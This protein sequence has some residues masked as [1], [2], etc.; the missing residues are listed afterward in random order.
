VEA[1]DD[2]EDIVIDR[3]LKQLHDEDLQREKANVFA[4]FTMEPGT[5]YGFLLTQSH[6]EGY[7]E[8]KLFHYTK[9]ALAFAWVVRNLFRC[10]K[11]RHVR[12]SWKFYLAMVVLVIFDVFLS[13]F[14]FHSFPAHKREKTSLEVYVFRTAMAIFD[15]IGLYILFARPDKVANLIPYNEA[16]ALVGCMYVIPATVCI[17]LV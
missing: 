4:M 2:P 14:S 7:E 15:F 11:T 5:I 10:K 16:L 13:W 9:F 3:V 1:L 8:Q 6:P 17:Y 12:L